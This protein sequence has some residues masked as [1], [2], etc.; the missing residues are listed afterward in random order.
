MS[1]SESKKKKKKKKRKIR[2]REKKKKKKKKKKMK[3]RY[4]QIKILRTVKNV[5]IDLK[6]SLKAK[7][8]KEKKHQF[9]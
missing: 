1:S 7:M 3:G 9:T 6:G 2:I 8:N 4:C 5:F